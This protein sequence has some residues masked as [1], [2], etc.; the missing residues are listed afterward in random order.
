MHISFYSEREHHRGYMNKV[1]I[2]ILESFVN[3]G[4]KDNKNNHFWPSR[5]A[6]K[7]QN[8]IQNHCPA[9]ISPQPQVSLRR[10]KSIKILRTFSKRFI[11]NIFS[12]NS[13]MTFID[14][15]YNII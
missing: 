5:G 10:L 15:I 7:H 13:L 6:I 9:L 3:Q 11:Q 4:D 2:R 12:Y 8:R 1:E 14:N